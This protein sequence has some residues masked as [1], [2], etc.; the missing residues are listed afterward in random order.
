MGVRRS[1]YHKSSNKR[2]LC[3]I[4]SLTT[5]VM[6]I[7]ISLS[8][9]TLTTYQPE[10]IEY[11][12][13][14]TKSDFESVPTENITFNKLSQ[15][16][17]SLSN[18]VDRNFIDF[19]PVRVAYMAYSNDIRF[20]GATFLKQK[21]NVVQYLFDGVYKINYQNILA[22]G[23]N[24]TLYDAP[25][26]CA[27]TAHLG[28]I[29]EW[30]SD[31]I[32]WPN[33]D[34]LKNNTQSIQLLSNYDV[35]ILYTESIQLFEYLPFIKNQTRFW[36]PC[37]PRKIDYLRKFER[38]PLKDYIHFM[39]SKHIH[40][41]ILDNYFYHNLNLPNINFH[42]KYTIKWIRDIIEKYTVNNYVNDTDNNVTIYVGK[43][44][45]QKKILD[46]FVDQSTSKFKIIQGHWTNVVDYTGFYRLLSTAKYVI[47]LEDSKSAGQIISEAAV[48]GIPVFGYN[49]KYFQHLLMPSY[50]Q[51]NNMNEIIDKIKFLEINK[52][53]YQKI[54]LE[55]LHS[56]DSYLNINNNSNSMRELIQ[57]AN[58]LIQNV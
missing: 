29:I 47:N 27:C 9:S 44:C 40:P 12:S 30:K 34:K 15:T 53:F 46:A 7:T 42:Y 21:T 32:L 25:F 52:Y 14:S 8:I 54:K 56:A 57:T 48:F 22:K 28:W 16:N 35:L 33:S 1:C 18:T 5:I 17:L 50:L 26:W 2:Q 39:K 43:R 31:I 13:E 10:I 41:V 20:G 6:I 55:I 23:E 4:L 45:R 37:E 11:S 36:E 3:K 24:G 38:E 58:K 49:K 19:D 51:V